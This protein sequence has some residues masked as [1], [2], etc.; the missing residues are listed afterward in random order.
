M[1]K[2]FIDTNIAIDLLCERYPW[3]DDAS[4]LFSMAKEKNTKLFANIR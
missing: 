4:E 2:V 3:F 1:T